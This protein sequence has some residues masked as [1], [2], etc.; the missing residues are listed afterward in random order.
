MNTGMIYGFLSIC[1]VSGTMLLTNMDT[2]GV[3]HSSKEGLFVHYVNLIKEAKLDLG[4]FEI[5]PKPTGCIEAVL[6]RTKIWGY[7][8]RPSTLILSNHVAQIE[9]I[10]YWLRQDE[11]LRDI[12]LYIDHETPV[13]MRNA[14]IASCLDHCSGEV[15]V[16]VAS[17][18]TTSYIQ[19]S[20]YSAKKPISL[21]K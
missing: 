5:K 18:G 14:L 17:N 19:L 7:G 21:P 11:A 15:F 9:E 16:A 13:D 3:S 8:S 10:P 2:R 4:A 20:D 1:L 6:G 12:V